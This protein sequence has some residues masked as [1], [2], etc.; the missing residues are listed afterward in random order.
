MKRDNIAGD[1]K[2]QAIAVFDIG[3]TNKKLLIFDL[4]MNLLESTHEKFEEY[5][6]DELIYEMVEEAWE[7]FKKNLK[8]MSG[9]YDIK[10]ISIAAHGAT[11]VCLNKEGELSMPVLSYETDPGEDFHDS[12]HGKFGDAIAL[13][14]STATPDMPCLGCLA[15]GIYFYM[16]RFP[17]EFSKTV[18]IL[19]LPQYFGFLLTGKK[20]IEYTYIGSHTYL[21]D[22]ASHDWSPLVGRLGLKDKLPE[23]ISNPWDILGTIT[24]KIS[25]ETGMPPNTLVT[26]GIHDSNASLLPYL[27]KVA[28]QPF[29][30][31][32]TGSVCVVMHPMNRVFLTED[33]LGKVIF[34]NLSAF[35]NPV[36]TAIFLA[37]L[38]FDAYTGIFRGI[39]G[40]RPFPVFNQDLVEKILSEKR[41]FILPAI[42]PFGMFPDSEARII[43]GDKVYSFGDVA[44]GNPPEF[45][46]DFDVAYTVLN[47][48]LA[49]HTGVALERVG[50]ESGPSIYIE[51]GF[52]KN[53]V[54]TKLLASMY[55]SSRV[56][57]TNLNEATAFG[58]A[59][60]AKSAIEQKT[61]ADIGDTF[62][63]E[64]R[65]ISPISL[66]GL[67][68]YAD[69]FLKRIKM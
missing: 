39:H 64:T 54:Y 47:L 52:S 8:I 18:S 19:N 20:G 40:D 33:E 63:I 37:G 14:R 5:Q 35:S 62:D 53:D 29:V 25:E 55:P 32:S 61:P 67:S 1:R 48:S 23:H 22:F 44:G 45:F 50:I 9:I 17:E 46:E 16:E 57:L 7:W 49:I 41:A 36:K 58:A 4:G 21:W 2:K 24:Q 11:C 28:E 26:M 60:L 34:Y 10:A 69:E 43:E 42:V 56:A 30:L 38:E 51:G 31:I 15:K 66:K 65:Q 68:E 13:Q 6:K 59:L 27:I 3:K 12:F